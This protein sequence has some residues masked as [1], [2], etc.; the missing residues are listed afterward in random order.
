[1]LATSNGGRVAILA[2]KYDKDDAARSAAAD[3]RALCTFA[4]GAVLRDGSVLV[5]VVPE[6]AVSRSS[7]RAVAS[8]L[9]EKTDDLRPVCGG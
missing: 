6:D 8:A 7:V 1:M 9:R 5:V 4:N 2:L 3:M